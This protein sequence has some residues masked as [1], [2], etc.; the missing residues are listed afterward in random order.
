MLSVQIQACAEDLFGP[1]HH[2]LAVTVLHASLQIKLWCTVPGPDC[3]LEDRKEKALSL[4][5]ASP[6]I[7]CLWDGL[8]TGDP[9]LFSLNKHTL[10]SLCSN[11]T[12]VVHSLWEVELGVCDVW[13]DLQRDWV[14]HKPT[15]WFSA[16]GETVCATSAWAQV[17]YLIL[18]VVIGSDSH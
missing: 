3:G 2:T 4:E 12:T 6:A 11:S 13:R 1:S 18:V 15:E 8:I 17:L 9:C 7:R 16:H 5:D 14:A 10:S